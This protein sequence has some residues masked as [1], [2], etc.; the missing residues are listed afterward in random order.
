MG[1]QLRCE[2]SSDQE[3]INLMGDQLR[4]EASCRSR[5][6]QLDGISTEMRSILQIKEISIRWE[7][8]RDAEHS[9]D[10]GDIK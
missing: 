7:I 8:N 4:C 1:D 6:Y 9:T 10:Q 2:A 3:D 5:R